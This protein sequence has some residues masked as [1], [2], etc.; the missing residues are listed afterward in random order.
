MVS[1]DGR[2]GSL[3]WRSNLVRL[4]ARQ[5]GVTI[6][7]LLDGA[8]HE[9]L[10]RLRELIDV[11]PDGSHVVYASTCTVYGD[12]AGNPCTEDAPLRLV[13]PH[14][15]LKKA[16]EDLLTETPRITTAVL[17]LGALYG[18]D[19]RRIRTDRVTKWLTEARDRQTITVP[20]P[21]HWRGWLHRDQAARAFHVAA[22][23]RV[24]GTFNV[25]A[26]NATFAEAVA[27]AA[28]LTD[29]EIITGGK[30]DLMDY[31]IEAERAR[32]FG[33]LTEAPGEDLAACTQAVAAQLFGI[34]PKGDDGA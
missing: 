24:S 11:L 1:R 25:A 34:S 31:Q 12:A 2:D 13:T 27:T 20:A 21:D 17:R 28:S 33:L 19:P 6:V 22:R 29:A 4:Q 5:D 18:P 15:R 26:A 23:E 32:G 9:E 14:A 3:A 10:D 7:W 8:K 16:G 30:R